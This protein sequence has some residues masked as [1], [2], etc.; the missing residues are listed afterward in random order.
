VKNL[1]FNAPLWPTTSCEA[2]PGSERNLRS[3]LRSAPL[4]PPYIYRRN[5]VGRRGRISCRNFAVPPAASA[6]A[7]REEAAPSP[8]TH[9]DF[10]AP[11]AE[12]DQLQF[13]ACTGRWKDMGGGCGRDWNLSHP[14]K[15]AE[16]AARILSG[17]HAHRKPLKTDRPCK[18]FR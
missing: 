13:P 12:G 1:V 2:Q 14:R 3:A 9:A 10:L 11:W 7:V 8:V 15:S 4:C 6:T 16:S 17:R 5:G 18:V